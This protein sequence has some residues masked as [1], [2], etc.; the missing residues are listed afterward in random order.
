VSLSPCITTVAVRGRL[1]RLVGRVGR[2]S[3]P[4]EAGA[5]ECGRDVAKGFELDGG[6]E[7]EIGGGVDE[8]PGVDEE[9]PSGVADGRLHAYSR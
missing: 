4:R 8:G 2:A 6:K 3:D 5:A 7:E 1:A 9:A